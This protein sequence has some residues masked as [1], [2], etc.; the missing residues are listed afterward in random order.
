MTITEFWSVQEIISEYLE[1]I[2]LLKVIT[3][4]FK[5]LSCSLFNFLINNLKLSNTVTNNI[6][7]YRFLLNFDWNIERLDIYMTN[8]VDCFYRI[9]NIIDYRKSHI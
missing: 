9:T 4:I 8:Y 7:K 2:V 1:E 3:W 6:L 5:V